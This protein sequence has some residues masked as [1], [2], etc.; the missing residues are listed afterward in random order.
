M[1]ICFQIF[2]TKN[3]KK[4]ITIKKGQEANKIKLYR[5]LMRDI[6]GLFCEDPVTPK[7][8]FDFGHR[9]VASKSFKATLT[10]EEI[11]DETPDF[12]VGDRVECEMS[13]LPFSFFGEVVSINQKL[14]AK[15]ESGMDIP[16][17]DL[18]SIKKIEE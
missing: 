7:G 17:W 11:S 16:I 3:L 10:I 5:D 12:K 8:F 1:M 14:F 9:Q 2:F 18:S 6:D 4:Q 15:T 13:S